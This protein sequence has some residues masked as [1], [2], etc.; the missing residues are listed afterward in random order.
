MAD[1]T[2]QSTNTP[3]QLRLESW[4]HY[5]ALEP[6]ST[7]SFLYFIAITGIHR[8]SPAARP[9][10]LPFSNKVLAQPIQSSDTDLTQ[11]DLYI[12]DIKDCDEELKELIKRKNK[13]NAIKRK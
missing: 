13:R 1:W 12:A 6:T 11:V 10:P 3:V 5:P 2:L 8:Q 9:S 7:Q 4:D